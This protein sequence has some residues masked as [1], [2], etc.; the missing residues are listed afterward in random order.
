[1]DN[2]FTEVKRSANIL[3]GVL[4]KY[5]RTITTYLNTLIKYRFDIISVVEPTPTEEAIKNMPELPKHLKG[6]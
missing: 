2:Y 5:H 1:M 6:Q 4:I 3:G